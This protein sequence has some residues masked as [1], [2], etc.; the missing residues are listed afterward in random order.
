MD[1]AAN[2]LARAAL[3][4]D[5]VTPDDATPFGLELSRNFVHGV[6]DVRAEGRGGSD[7]RNRDQRG[8]QTVFDGGGARF[9]GS[10]ASEEVRHGKVPTVYTQSCADLRRLEH[11]GTHRD[12]RTGVTLPAETLGEVNGA[13]VQGPETAAQRVSSVA[14]QKRLDAIV[15][16]PSQYSNICLSKSVCPAHVKS[17][18]DH[19]THR[20]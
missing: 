20:R 3:K 9:I 6:A 2:A 16:K 17:N 15:Y 5:Q 10:E 12:V 11:L 18:G 19:V 8:D 13:G 1:K 14:G 4:V 7:D